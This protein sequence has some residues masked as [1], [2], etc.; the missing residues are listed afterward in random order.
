MM[1][2]NPIPLPMQ[3]GAGRIRE[4]SKYYRVWHS[5]SQQNKDNFVISEVLVDVV[6][7]YNHDEARRRIQNTYKHHVLR[8][9]EITEPSEIE[10]IKKQL[11]EKKVKEVV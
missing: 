9:E 8:V 3:L 6:K 11:F 1:E 7:S 5:K 4:G 2:I 10:E